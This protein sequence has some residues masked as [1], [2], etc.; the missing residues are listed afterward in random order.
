MLSCLLILAIIHKLNYGFGCRRD[1]NFFLNG[2]ITFSRLMGMALLI[3]IYLF[4]GFR[5]I[6]VMLI[7]LFAMVWTNSK[8]PLLAL[9][10]TLLYMYFNSAEKR[11]R[12]P[13][14]LVG[15]FTSLIVCFM[16]WQFTEI[17]KLCLFNR[18]PND[19]TSSSYSVRLEMM[20][21]SVREII[22][23]PIIGAGLGDW[24]LV[25]P[26]KYE[27]L[28]PHN[29]FLEVFVEF[30][31]IFGCVFLIPYFYFIL[32]LDR[33]NIF[34]TLALFHFIAQQVSGDI[35]DGRYIVVFSV[36]SLLVNKGFPS[37]ES[38]EKN[39]PLFSS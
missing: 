4:A 39:Q 23:Q 17:N 21:S 6:V 5:R 28:Y 14:I 13:D 19:I 33:N 26:N 20:E 24:A 11:K 37:P 31:L 9:F 16:L 35:L 30:G 10:I 7:F 8:G 22:S 18:F 1:V 38:K 29:I 15:T 2:P 12:I 25:V 32:F 36:L 3:S 27:L 34:S